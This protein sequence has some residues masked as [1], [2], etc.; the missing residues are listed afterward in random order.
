MLKS[1]A[2]LI[3][4]NNGAQIPTPGEGSD[5]PPEFDAQFYRESH[6]DLAE[7]TDEQVLA[8]F[9][10][11]GRIEGRVGHPA[12]L[13]DGF[14]QLIDPHLPTL[15]IGPMDTPVLR[16][17]KVSYFDV[18]DT[19]GLRKRCEQHGRS[20]QNCPHIDFVSP[21]GDLSVVDA[22]FD[23]VVSSHAI[24]HQPDL[25]AHLEGVARLLRPGGR[26]FVLVPDR[27]YCFDHF[28]PD[29]N[30]ADVIDA[31]LRKR[32]VHEP[33]KIIEHI[34]MTTHNDPGRHWQGDHGQPVWLENPERIQAAL[35]WIRAHPGEYFDCHAW[36]FTPDSFR[37]TLGGL[38]AY[39]F[40]TMKPLRVF[41]T[42][43]GRLEFCAVLE[44][45]EEQVT[46]G[47]PSAPT[48]PANFDPASYLAA[49]PDVA[50]AGCDAADHF[51]A[52]GHREGRPLRP[53]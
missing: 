44:R 12:A 10:Q 40:T 28:L 26:Y 11:F 32:Q 7:L 50:R 51:L 46:A 33:R 13:R 47:S 20:A 6:P 37:R 16:G 15:E 48:L 27:R 29:S 34:A 17:P 21:H 19:D 36:Q 14:V 1:L 39:G 41:D 25:V 8:H 30:L 23:A 3:R 22:C 2:R 43:R 5:L 53:N 4:R 9:V 31:H 45:C 49:N 52:H 18:L 24:E 38:H 35:N 42:P